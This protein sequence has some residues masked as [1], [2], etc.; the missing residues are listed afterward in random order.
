MEIQKIASCNHFQK[1]NPWQCAVNGR[2]AGRSC[3]L[4]GMD[5]DGFHFDRMIE[6][7]SFLTIFWSRRKIMD[8]YLNFYNIIRDDL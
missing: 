7:C 3:C 1:H 2:T 8:I 4:G 5:A 6:K